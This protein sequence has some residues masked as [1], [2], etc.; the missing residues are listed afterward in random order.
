MT[1]KVILEFPYDETY[2]PTNR[3]TRRVIRQLSQEGEK[4]FL[5][6]RGERRWNEIPSGQAA[7]IK[8]AYS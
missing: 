1:K 6:T 2:G 5:R 3:Q 7:E 8:R 4:Y